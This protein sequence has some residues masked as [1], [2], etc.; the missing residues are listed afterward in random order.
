MYEYGM[1]AAFQLLLTW[2]IVELAVAQKVF[3]L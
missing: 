1:K 2:S 3:G